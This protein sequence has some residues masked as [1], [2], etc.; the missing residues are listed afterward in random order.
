MSDGEIG[1]G[2]QTCR[3]QQFFVLWELCFKAAEGEE[4]IQAHCCGDNT[5]IGIKDN[6][7]KVSFVLRNWFHFMS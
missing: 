4:F 5:Q 3:F 2:E 7:Q 1:G 6:V